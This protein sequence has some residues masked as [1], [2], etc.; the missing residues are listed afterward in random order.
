MIEL[1]S[2]DESLAEKLRKVN[3]KQI[4]EISLLEN[5]SENHI[6]KS[7]V[8]TIIAVIAMV[9]AAKIES[10]L[11]PGLLLSLEFLRQFALA[12]QYHDRA[13]EK[14]KVLNPFLDLAITERHQTLRRE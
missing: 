3:L 11:I 4:S 6:E 1:I 8:A 5:L 13:K 7:M 2:P 14:Q 9:G 12:H 10:S